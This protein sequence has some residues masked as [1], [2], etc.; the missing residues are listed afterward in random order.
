MP[1]YKLIGLKRGGRLCRMTGLVSRGLCGRVCVKRQDR[2]I[3][4]ARLI[5]VN[6][7]DLKRIGIVDFMW[8]Y[9]VGESRKLKRVL[10]LLVGKLLGL[11]DGTQARHFIFSEV[12][13]GGRPRGYEGLGGLIGSCSKPQLPGWPPV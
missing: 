2:G 1:T 5:N 10:Y 3:L 12:G 4:P 9:L 11:L 6:T 7:E 8:V 13:V